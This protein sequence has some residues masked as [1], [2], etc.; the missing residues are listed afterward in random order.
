M[1]HIRTKHPKFYLKKDN[2][3]FLDFY[4]Q[5]NFDK[6]EEISHNQESEDFMGKSIEYVEIP[7]KSIKKDEIFNNTIP[8]NSAFFPAGGNSAFNLINNSLMNNNHIMNNNLMNNNPIM[9]NNLTNKNTRESSTQTD[10]QAQPLQNDYEFNGKLVNFCKKS[11]DLIDY[12]HQNLMLNNSNASLGMNQ[13]DA[14]FN[15]NDNILPVK[16]Q[17]DSI[18]YEIEKRRKISSFLE[19]YQNVKVMH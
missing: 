8:R 13:N 17:L 14:L 12:V 15:F 2:Y 4:R 1:F 5:H 19:Y 16:S 7:R 6:T 18:Y 9:N 11:I 3:Q 10:F